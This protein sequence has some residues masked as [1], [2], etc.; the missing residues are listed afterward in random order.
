MKKTLNIKL[1]ISIFLVVI[2]C[3]LLI[4]GFIVPP[5]GVIDSS[6]L[7]AYGEVATFA[8][9]LLGVDYKYKYMMYK[10]ELLKKSQQ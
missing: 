10:D 3:G 9:S 7:V 8:G 6:L 4:A 2:G 1:F 5:L